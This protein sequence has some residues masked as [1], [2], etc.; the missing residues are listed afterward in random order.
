MFDVSVYVYCAAAE[1]VP[2]ATSVPFKRTYDLALAVRFDDEQNT[3][4][5]VPF[6]SVSVCTPVYFV[7]STST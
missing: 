3:V 6:S 2:V 7:P 4:I 5:S 1:L